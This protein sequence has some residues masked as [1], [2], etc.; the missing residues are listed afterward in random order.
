MAKKLRRKSSRQY[1]AETRVILESYGVQLCEARARAG[2]TARELAARAHT[3][4]QTIHAFEQG[5]GRRVDVLM[6]IAREL[7]LQVCLDSIY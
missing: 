4:H 6:R 3:T 5:K 1:D 2:L 7:D